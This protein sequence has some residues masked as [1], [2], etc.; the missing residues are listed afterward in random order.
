MAN[1]STTGGYLLPDGAQPLYDLELE[2]LFQAAVAA[3]TNLPG[4]MVRPRWQ[5]EAPAQP[6]FATSWAAVGVSVVERD[7]NPYQVHDPNA[8]TT[9]PPGTGADRV[10]YDEKLELF[11]SF[12][13][14]NSQA[15]VNQFTAGLQVPQ[16][17]WP[18]QSYGI[19]LRDVGKPVYLPALLKEVNVKRTDLKVL[20]TRRVVRV[21]P[22]RHLADATATVSTNGGGATP[23][24]T[25]V[26]VTP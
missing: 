26:N 22:I 12:Y 8:V 20:W 10:E 7:Q 24:S 5:P 25:T 18:L 3:I 11:L 14:P 1:D 23:F 13:G 17:R 4:A 6:A 16:N 19:K 21:Y 15:L 2:K 9:S